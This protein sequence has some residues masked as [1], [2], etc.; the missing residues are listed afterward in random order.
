MKPAKNRKPSM[1]KFIIFSVLLFVVIL[2]AGSISFV[3]SMRQIIRTNKSNELSQ[4]LET[5][6]IRLEASLKSEIAIVLKLANSPLV[7]KHLMNPTDPELEE[8]A[9]EEIES[10]RDAFSGYSIFWMNDI[11]RIFYSDDNT[12]YWVDADDPVNYWYYLTIRD[13]EVY[14]FNINYNPAIDEI[15]LW[16]NAP[17]FDDDHN[18]V[19][20]VGTGIELSVF[21]DT[22]YKN[23][24]ERTELYFFVADGKIYGARD[25]EL[26]KE[27]ANIAD[28]LKGSEIDALIEAKNIESGE[29]KLFD[30]SNGIVAVGSISLPDW[31]YTAKIKYSGADYDTAMTAL[32]LVVLVLIMLIFIIFNVFV[33]RFLKSLRKASDDLAMATRVREQE[34]IADN[35]M[36]DRLNRMKI[37]F[38]QNMNHDF[39]TPLTVISVS[40]LDAVD[41]LDCANE[42]NKDEM[43]GTLDDAQREIMR[44][45]RMVDSAVKQAS[46]YDNRQD[47]EPVDIA[48]IMRKGAETHR[49]LLERHGNTLS[50]DIPQALPQI[51][52]NADM[53][54]HVL[55]NLI[56]NA[57]RY[58]RGGE[59]GIKATVKS[60]AVK[61]TVQDNGTGVN[62]ELL[63]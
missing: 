50:I 30:I 41:M 42:I 15:K 39:K 60:N 26:I 22:T 37:E 27:R 33:T 20:M 23:I 55:S 21:V 44:M 19:G 16:I 36:L 62:P 5:E 1:G 11:D 29:T 56:S 51:Y 24:D 47:M 38:F 6:K 13:T 2:A 49:V 40:I 10:Y 52:G 58:T 4:T 57:N 34:L 12:P 31:Y 8:V 45:G 25:V 53:L 46:L 14:N 59:I 3:F 28:V 18:A 17:V 9:R 32:F 7:K 35:D 48:P 61:V 54:L 63:P 43:R